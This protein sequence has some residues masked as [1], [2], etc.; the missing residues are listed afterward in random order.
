MADNISQPSVTTNHENMKSENSSSLIQGSAELSYNINGNNI[1]CNNKM[2]VSS[3]SFQ[4]I[5]HN[6]A[7]KNDDN[8]P[9]EG[10]GRWT[11]DEHIK[12]I[13]GLKLFGKDWFKIQNYIGTRSSA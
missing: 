3:L 7:S 5:S 8:M 2:E 9:N 6:S 10:N 12:F 4:D 1:L 11:Q 13:K